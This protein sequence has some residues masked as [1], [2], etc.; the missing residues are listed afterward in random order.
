MADKIEQTRDKIQDALN[1]LESPGG[2]A[3]VLMGL[4]RERLSSSMMILEAAD[5]ASTVPE[6]AQAIE[7]A[8]AQG[9]DTPEQ[10]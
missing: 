2:E 4:V 10:A 1:N 3:G 7:D 8:Q 5:R 9:T 6:V